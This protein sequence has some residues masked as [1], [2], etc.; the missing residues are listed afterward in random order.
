[1]TKKDKIFIA[2]FAAICAIGL[3]LYPFQKKRISSLIKN[4]LRNTYIYLCPPSLDYEKHWGYYTAIAKTT[5]PN[6]MTD[7]II[8]EL[9]NKVVLLEKEVYQE[10]NKLSDYLSNRYPVNYVPME[11][12]KPV[13]DEWQI[14]IN[15]QKSSIDSVRN[16]IT[17][18]YKNDFHPSD[19]LVVVHYFSYNTMKPPYRIIYWMDS[20]AKSI[21]KKMQVNEF[22]NPISVVSRSTGVC[23]EYDIVFDQYSDRLRNWN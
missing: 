6:P 12:R 3:L 23:F 16:L 21:K 5:A 13:A 14:R 22:M 9:A 15:Q 7:S 10:E 2:A 20:D 11:K 19:D 18:R 4:D 8:V 17:N 1:M